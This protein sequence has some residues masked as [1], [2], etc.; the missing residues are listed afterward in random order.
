[1]EMKKEFRV[2]YNVLVSAHVVSAHGSPSP[3]QHQKHV[4]IRSYLKIPNVLFI[5]Y[6][7]LGIVFILLE[8]NFTHKKIALMK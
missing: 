6:G 2:V 5:S 3:T 8:Y 1:M 4:I 7:L